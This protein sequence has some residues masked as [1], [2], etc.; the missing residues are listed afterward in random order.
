MPKKTY[1]VRL[2]PEL[3]RVLAGTRENG[4]GYH[5]VD[6]KMKN[7]RVIKNVPVLNSEIAQIPGEFAEF[8]AGDIAGLRLHSQ[9]E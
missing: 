8:R 6:I 3:V 5:I 2:R 7:G 1:D 9:A 4:I